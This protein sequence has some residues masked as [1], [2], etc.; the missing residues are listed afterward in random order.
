MKSSV[1]LPPSNKIKKNLKSVPSKKK[2]ET[3]SIKTPVKKEKNIRFVKVK[4]STK[5]YG[6]QLVK[7]IEHRF[8]QAE[9]GNMTNDELDALYVLVG[10]LKVLG[11]DGAAQS[12][13][14]RLSAL[15]KKH[16]DKK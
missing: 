7:K 3:I 14:P 16:S 12:F 11:L 8:A 6:K 9:Q 5:R 2:V 10:S 15:K 13:M 4:H 1:K